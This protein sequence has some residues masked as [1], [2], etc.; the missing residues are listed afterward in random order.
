VESISSVSFRKLCHERPGSKYLIQSLHS[1]P[2]QLIPEIPLFFLREISKK[3]AES[4][5]LDPFCGT[6]TVMVE[7]MRNG[8]NSIGVDVNPI[9]ALIAKV[10]TTMVSEAKL[11]EGLEFIVDLF[12]HLNEGKI[13]APKFKNMSFWFD[14]KTIRILAKIKYCLS[15]ISDKDVA[16]FFKVIFSSIVKDVSRADPRIY[17]PVLPNDNY[18]TPISDAWLLF[19]NKAEIGIKQMSEFSNLLIKPPPSCKI[20]CEDVRDFN[21][22]GKNI[23]LIITSPPYISAQKYL[24]SVRLQANWLGYDA[25]MQK[26]IEEGTIGTERTSKAYYSNIQLTGYE[27]LDELIKKIYGKNRERAGIVSKYFI[28]MEQALN[29][30]FSILNSDGVL[31]LVI[32]TN[33]AAK[34][35]VDTNKFLM[36]ICQDIGF[37]VERIM[38]D[39]IVSRSLMTKR[40]TTAGIIDYEWVIQMRKK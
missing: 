16:D 1:Y 38:R 19:R 33:T 4:T 6:G 37:S 18:Q 26:E 15:E 39:K 2:A 8:W 36:K 17:V 27:N 28:E 20:F 10:K 9:A 13:E 25:D 11:G 35:E 34:Y 22:N 29:H 3:S 24:R 14:E 5:V 12:E 32:G 7:A 31:V 30:L 40:N 23:D 21:F